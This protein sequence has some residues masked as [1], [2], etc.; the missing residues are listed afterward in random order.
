MKR[1]RQ[2]AHR[3]KGCS[4]EGSQWGCVHDA[5]VH[6]IRDVLITEAMTSGFE[7]TSTVLTLCHTQPLQSVIPL[8]PRIPVPLIRRGGGHYRLSTG[9]SWGRNGVSEGGRPNHL[10]TQNQK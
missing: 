3:D 10:P 7:I 2:G 8:S 5:G 9:L 1:K 4:E 6:S